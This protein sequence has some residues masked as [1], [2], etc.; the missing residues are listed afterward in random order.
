MRQSTVQIYLWDI[1]GSVSEAIVQHKLQL[2][3]LSAFW[4]NTLIL[5]G[6]FLSVSSLRS[7]ATRGES[8]YIIHF[9]REKEKVCRLILFGC[10]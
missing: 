2:I 8:T 7:T 9:I 1:C 10:L 3:L 4:R 5:T 6:P